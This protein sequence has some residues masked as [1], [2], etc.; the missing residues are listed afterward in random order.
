MLC[1]LMS[2]P[3]KKYNPCTGKSQCRADDLFTLVRI[4]NN[5]YRSSLNLFISTKRTTKGTEK[6]NFKLITCISDQGYGY[7]VKA[8]DDVDIICYASKIYV[9]QSLHRRGLY[10]YHFY[11]NNP[12]VSR[13][14]KTIREL[15]YWKGLVM[16]V[17]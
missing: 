2:K 9:P 4:E 15:C 14:A 3:S 17:H 10:C 1:I 8:L 13:L 11:L 7:Y 16:Q 12:S 5:E 6:C